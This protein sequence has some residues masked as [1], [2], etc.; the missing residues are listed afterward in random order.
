MLRNLLSNA[1]KFTPIDG[2]VDVRVYVSEHKLHVEVRDNGVGIS[3]ENQQRLFNKIIQFNA[4]AQQAGGGTGLGLWICKRIIDMHGGA[5]GMKSDGEGHGSTFYFSLHINERGCNRSEVEQ[6]TGDN[7]CDDEAVVNIPSI[8]ESEDRSSRFFS[9]RHRGVLPAGLKANSVHPMPE[10]FQISSTNLKR[11]ELVSLKSLNVLVVDDSGLN[12]KMMVQRMRLEGCCAHEADDGDAALEAIHNSFRD[13]KCKYD[14]ITMDNVKFIFIRFIVDSY[15]IFSISGNA[16]NARYR[17]S[18]ADPTARL[19]WS[20]HRRYRKRTSGGRE[21]FH[22]PWSRCGD[23]KALR[24]RR[25]Q[26]LR[27]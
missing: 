8:R 20:H 6:A 21:G 1:I 15:S 22:R 17:G 13:G 16:T 5:M 9:E 7:Y 12:R 26:A 3:P 2:R 24:H 14:I 25:F 27:L 23:T 11:E 19:Q 18:A 4:K 10:H